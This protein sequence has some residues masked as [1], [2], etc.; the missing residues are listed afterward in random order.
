MRASVLGLLLLTAVGIASSCGGRQRAAFEDPRKNEITA[1]WTQIRDWRLEA[2]LGVEP[3]VEDVNALV[4]TPVREILRV[5]PDSH[6]VTEACSNVCSLADAICDNAEQI[7]LL[8]DQLGKGDSW[9]QDKCSNAKASCRDAKKK[10]C[11]KCSENK[12]SWTGNPPKP[13]PAGSFGS[14][15]ARGGAK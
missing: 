3:R 14:A 15:P 11:M 13:A 8:A 1:L 6:P 4:R 12:T 5:C 10:C 9:A 7:C 2:E